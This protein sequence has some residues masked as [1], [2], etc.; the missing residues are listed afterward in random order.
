MSRTIYQVT[1]NR[2][3]ALPIPSDRRAAAKVPSVC[4]HLTTAL[5]LP[6]K[7]FPTCKQTQTISFIKYDLIGKLKGPNRQ[8]MQQKAELPGSPDPQNRGSLAD[9]APSFLS[10]PPQPCSQN[11]GTFPQCTDFPP[12]PPNEPLGH[13][14]AA[15]P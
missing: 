2:T 13:I 6:L 7:R 9:T 11:R 15:P 1:G 4:N 10:A 14:A 3:L 5:Q 12:L 8:M